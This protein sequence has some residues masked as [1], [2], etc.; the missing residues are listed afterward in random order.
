MHTEKGAAEHCCRTAPG[1]NNRSPASDLR[2][3]KYEH[4]REVQVGFHPA[5]TDK[6]G[7]A[8]AAASTGSSKVG[9]PQLAD[10]AH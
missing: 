2:G 3:Q 10:G 5:P 6:A 9:H 8:L 7:K 4:L 1:V